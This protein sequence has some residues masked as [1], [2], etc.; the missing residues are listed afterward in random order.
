MSQQPSEIIQD[1]EVDEKDYRVLVRYC[2]GLDFLLNE[3]FHKSL[4]AEVN[5]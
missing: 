4:E 5:L 1:V 3:P 2:A